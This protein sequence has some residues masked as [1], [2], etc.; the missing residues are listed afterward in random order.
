MRCT[1]ALRLK[2]TDQQARRDRDA[3]STAST[4]SSRRSRSCPIDAVVSPARATSYCTACCIGAKARFET[5]ANDV[6]APVTHQARLPGG[7]RCSKESPW[8]SLP[9]FK[10]AM[11][12]RT[13]RIANTGLTR[14][15]YPKGRQYATNQRTVPRDTWVG[16]DGVRRGERGSVWEDE[17]EKVDARWGGL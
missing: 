6:P 11:R 13:G 14:S 10:L 16:A 1:N 17:E 12:A 2:Q 9:K 4:G 3:S 15:E 7:G 5:R 8:K